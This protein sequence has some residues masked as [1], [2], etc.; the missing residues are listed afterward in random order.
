[1][2]TEKQQIELNDREEDKTAGGFIIMHHVIL[3]STSSSGITTSRH[4]SHP[5]GTECRLAGRP[6]WFSGCAYGGYI[7]T[8]CI[9]FCRATLRPTDL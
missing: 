5:S 7:T 2:D 3:S 8:L 1:M 4:T 9:F 6:N